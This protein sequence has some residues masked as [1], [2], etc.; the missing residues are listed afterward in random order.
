MRVHVSEVDGK[1]YLDG[2]QAGVI[3]DDNEHSVTLTKGMSRAALVV[4]CVLAGA[5]WQRQTFA[6]F[7]GLPLGT[8]P[9]MPAPVEAVGGAEPSLAEL[10]PLR[11]N[12][13]LRGARLLTEAL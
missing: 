1:L 12:R 4:A 5:R 13:R 3:F 9:V 7:G 10:I 8:T 2:K 6:K 11:R